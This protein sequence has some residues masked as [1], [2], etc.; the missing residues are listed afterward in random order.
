MKIALITLAAALTQCCGAPSIEE[1]IPRRDPSLQVH[2][3]EFL[4][5]ARNRGIYLDD[6]ALRIVEYHELSGIAVG[7]CTVWVNGLRRIRVEPSWKDERRLKALM[8]H[9]LGHCLLNIWEHEDE[10]SPYMM[11]PNLHPYEHY[12]SDWNYL[13]NQLF[14]TYISRL[15]EIEEN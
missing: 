1:A 3:L 4:E 15:P 7:I 2:V 8:Y 5:D 14:E 12:E 9:E 13:V 11:A 10:D 6:S